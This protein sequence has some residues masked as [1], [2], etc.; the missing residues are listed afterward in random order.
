MTRW[1]YIWIRPGNLSPEHLRML[2]EQGWEWAGT[3]GDD[4]ILFKRL[5]ERPIMT[6][7]GQ[8]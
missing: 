4:W 2:G 6:I 8:E 5:I 7:E 3:L 1:E